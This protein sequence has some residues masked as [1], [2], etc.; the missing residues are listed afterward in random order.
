MFAS[1]GDNGPPCGEPSSVL[2]I[3]PFSITPLFRY[4]FIK[5]STRISG[6]CRCSRVMSSSWFSVSKYL[7]RSTDKAYRYPSC[8]PHYLFAGSPR[9][10]GRSPRSLG[11]L[12]STHRPPFRSVLETYDHSALPLKKTQGTMA[13]ADFLQFV[14]T[15]VFGFSY[16]PSARPPRVRTT[17]F[18]PCN[19]HIYRTGFGQHW[20][21]CWIAHSSVPVRP[22]M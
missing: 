1:K 7:D 22:T 8:V 10:L 18:L 5:R 6:I 13:S 14:V 15:A 16:L 11:I 20:T 2:Q 3:T 19:H 21:L 4:F 17:T 12:L 9:S